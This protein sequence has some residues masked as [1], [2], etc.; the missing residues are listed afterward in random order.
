MRSTVRHVTRKHKQAHARF[1]V[2]VVSDLCV[3]G[4]TLI[5]TIDVYDS[6]HE[7]IFYPSSMTIP[8]PSP[9]LLKLDLY[10]EGSRPEACRKPAGFFN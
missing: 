1:V 9:E 6:P 2:E 3:G 10:V 4:L 8:N 7:S 5:S